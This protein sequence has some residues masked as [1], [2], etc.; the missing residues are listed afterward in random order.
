M[1][2]VKCINSQHKE[3]LIVNNIYQVSEEGETYGVGW[4]RI[5]NIKGACCKDRFVLN[6]E[7]NS[8]IKIL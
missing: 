2:R 5:E 1:K 8:N 6:I 4:Y 3:G 7:L